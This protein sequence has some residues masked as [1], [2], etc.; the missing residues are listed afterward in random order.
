MHAEVVRHGATG[1]NSRSDADVPAA[2]V[3]AVRSAALVVAGE[4]Y[5]H[6]LVTG[7]DEPEASSDEE[8]RNEE[9][10]DSVT[11]SEDKVCDDIQRHAG[12]DEVDEV[13]TVDE[14]ARHDAVQNETC[15]DEGV[16]PAGTADAE[17]LGVK[18]DV[19]GD[20]AVGET[21]E[22]EVCKLR[23]GAREEESVERKRGVRFFLFAGNA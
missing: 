5:A 10:G 18:R 8:C 23:D 4:V 11:E 6:G 12:T 7:E 1:E 20:R 22:Y 17:F 16:K 14:T 2:E 9:C 15:G 19:V 21:D 3:R 13:A